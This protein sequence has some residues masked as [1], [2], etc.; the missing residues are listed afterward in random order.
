MGKQNYLKGNEVRISISVHG[1][2]DMN[3]GVIDVEKNS[4][5]EHNFIIKEVEQD[6]VLTKDEELED[7]GFEERLPIKDDIIEEVFE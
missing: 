6:Q 4:I 5:Y 1:G 3:L 7:K 2:K